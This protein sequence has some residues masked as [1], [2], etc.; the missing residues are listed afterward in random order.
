MTKLDIKT[1]EEEQ[2]VEDPKRDVTKDHTIVPA[3]DRSALLVINVDSQGRPSTVKLTRQ[4]SAVGAHHVVGLRMSSRP[5]R[6]V[7]IAES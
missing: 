1:F 4:V 5:S 7:R 3:L 6:N 2:D